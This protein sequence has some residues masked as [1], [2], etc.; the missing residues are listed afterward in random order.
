MPKQEESVG[1]PQGG[2]FKATTTYIK[3]IAT[4]NLMKFLLL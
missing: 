1:K 2:M 4:M 3:N